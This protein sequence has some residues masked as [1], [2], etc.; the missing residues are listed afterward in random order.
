MGGGQPNVAEDFISQLG[1]AGGVEGDILENLGQGGWEDG[2]IPEPMAQPKTSGGSRS[3]ATIYYR[4]E[5]S[6][7]RTTNTPPNPAGVTASDIAAFHGLI[8]P[9]M[10]PNETGRS[11][12][13]GGMRKVY[14]NDP[15][16]DGWEEDWL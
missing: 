7:L 13:N 4:I 2:V 11:K 16:I 6:A 8:E 1:V 12:R 14:T 9:I 5:G 15:L 3:E 10:V